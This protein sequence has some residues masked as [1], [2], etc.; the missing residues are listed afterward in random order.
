LK[1]KARTVAV[2]AIFASIYATV[3]LTLAP[4]SFMAI[5]CRVADAL[6]PLIGLFGWP[7][8]IGI[9]IG[10]FITNTVSPLGPIDLLSPLVLL[11]AKWL[12]KRFGFRAVPVFAVSVGL[13][14]AFMLSVMFSQPYWITMIYVTIGE[15]IASL[16]FGGL[17][18][19]ALVRRLRRF[20]PHGVLDNNVAA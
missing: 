20:Q 4:I 1:S 13:W 18:Y 10:E 6:Y 8:I 17:L 11:P 2:A 14:V 9:T 15:G 3:S 12:I 19:A 7:A 16:G 5:Q